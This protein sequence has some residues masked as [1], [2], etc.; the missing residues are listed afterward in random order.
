[1]KSCPCSSRFSLIGDIC[2]RIWLGLFETFHESS[3][4]KVSLSLPPESRSAWIGLKEC[5]H[6]MLI[7]LYRFDSPRRICTWHRII[8]LSPNYVREG[9]FLLVWLSSYLH[10]VLRALRFWLTGA[11][12]YC[13]SRGVCSVSFLNLN[14]FLEFSKDGWTRALVLNWTANRF[15]GSDHMARILHHFFLVHCAALCPVSPHLMH[16]PSLLGGPDGASLRGLVSESKPASVMR[17]FDPLHLLYSVMPDASIPTVFSKISP[18]IVS[19][20]S[21]VASHVGMWV[22]QRWH[23]ASLARSY[24]HFER[25]PSSVRGGKSSISL[26]AVTQPKIREACLHSPCFNADKINSTSTIPACSSYKALSFAYSWLISVGDSTIGLRSSCTTVVNSRTIASTSWLDVIMFHLSFLA[27]W[28]RT[29]LEHPCTVFIWRCSWLTSLM[30]SGR[31]N[32]SWKLSTDLIRNLITL[33]SATS[34]I[35]L[36]LKSE[37]FASWSPTNDSSRLRC[38]CRSEIVSTHLKCANRRARCFDQ[39]VNMV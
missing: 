20:A 23:A 22:K 30:T 5:G 6:S 9:F 2:S 15:V 13:F 31:N 18:R 7:V 25:T 26:P 32:S 28:T 11:F 34:G 36:M 17:S 3:I 19:T 37:N 38:T 33:A 27:R 39:Q 12:S 1:M 4:Q 24:D 29:S 10:D 16:W 8:Y 21:S 14:L 35:L